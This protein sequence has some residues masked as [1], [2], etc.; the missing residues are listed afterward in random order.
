[1][2]LLLIIVLAD[3]PPEPRLGCPIAL[4]ASFASLVRG[5]FGKTLSQASLDA[6]AMTKESNRGQR[7]AV[8]GLTLGG[9]GLGAF[10]DFARVRISARYSRSMERISTRN[11]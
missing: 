5:C 1:M 8:N 10:C 4:D 7:H 6:T 2:W 9:S 3:Y 11:N